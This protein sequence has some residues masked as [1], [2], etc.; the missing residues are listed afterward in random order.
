MMR[1]M[2]VATIHS[3]SSRQPREIE[4]MTASL[5]R[6]ARDLLASG[7]HSPGE[8][9]FDFQPFGKINLEQEFGTIGVQFGFGLVTN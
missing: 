5:Q 3:T 9:K 8:T 2:D 6:R 7:N 4:N 1:C